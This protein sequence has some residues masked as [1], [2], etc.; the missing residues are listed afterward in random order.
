MRDYVYFA[1]KNLK[2]YDTYITNAGVYNAPARNYDSIPIAGRSGNLIFENDNF[3]NIEYRYP[4]VITENFDKNIEALRAF[5]LSQRGYKRL[6]DTFYPDEF[7]LATFNRL[8]SVSQKFLKGDKGTFVMVFERKPQR[9]LKKGEKKLVFTAA[10]SF[11]NPTQFKALPFITVY[12]NGTLTIN[13]VS[14]VIDTEYTH[15]DI[16]CELQEVLQT[17]GN[18]DITLTNGEF[19][20]LDKGVNEVSFTGLTRVEITPRWYTL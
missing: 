9:F 12:G 20:H 1:G 4:A 15:L 10:G 16:D 2:D 14:I 11:K 19:P 5:L 18:L 3:E 6:S 13:G 8:D 7:Y 17:E